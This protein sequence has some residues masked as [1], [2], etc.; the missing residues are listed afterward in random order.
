MSRKTVQK[1]VDHTLIAQLWEFK[2]LPVRELQW[3]RWIERPRLLTEFL[4]ELNTWKLATRVNDTLRPKDYKKKFSRSTV[5]SWFLGR[6]TPSAHDAEILRR[7]I[8]WVRG[9]RPYRV[10]KS[11][12]SVPTAKPP[13]RVP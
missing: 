10:P 12:I 1:P 6:R 4:A 9:K 11:L 13:Y 3:G 8:C 2:N 5:Q 7:K